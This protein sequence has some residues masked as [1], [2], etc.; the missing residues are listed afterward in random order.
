MQAQGRPPMPSG[1]E[2]A[3]VQPM[4]RRPQAQRDDRWSPA[5]PSDPG[6]PSRPVNAT[7]T[8]ETAMRSY[9]SFS[10]PA[11]RIRSGPPELTG[12]IMIRRSERYDLPALR[13]LAELDGRLLPA[14]SFLLAEI[15]DELVAAAPL[16]TDEEPMTDPFRPTGDVRELLR[17]NARRIRRNT[18]PGS[19]PESVFATARPRRCPPSQSRGRW[20]QTHDRRRRARRTC[21]PCCRVP[22]SVQPVARPVRRARGPFDWKAAASSPR[23]TRPCGGGSTSA[24]PRRTRPRG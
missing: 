2:A 6:W 16:D 24:S 15:G 23:P 14:G 21:R 10:T 7:I 22:G 1:G 20:P 18:A 11:R 5:S 9:T 17:T 4:Y 12:T 8:R 13:R 19:L 3:N